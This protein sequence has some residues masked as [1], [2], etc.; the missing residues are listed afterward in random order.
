[1]HGR[2]L[3]GF[4]VID[5]EFY[6]EHGYLM[7]EVQMLAENSNDIDTLRSWNGIRANVGSYWNHGGNDGVTFE[8]IAEDADTDDSNS[9][10]DGLDTLVEGISTYLEEKENGSFVATK[11]EVSEKPVENT[12]APKQLEGY[13]ANDNCPHCNAYQ[14]LFGGVSHESGCP[15][16]TASIF[17]LRR[18]KRA[19]KLKRS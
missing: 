15:N 12:I 8:I 9:V 16:K 4:T 6:V 5:H 19:G 11:K 1:L 3:G 13:E 17:S 18:F 10:R 7:L 2:E 14:S